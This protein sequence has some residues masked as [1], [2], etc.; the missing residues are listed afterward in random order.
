MAVKMIRLA[1]TLSTIGTSKEVWTLNPQNE[2]PI[3]KVA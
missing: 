2:F 3:V 1:S